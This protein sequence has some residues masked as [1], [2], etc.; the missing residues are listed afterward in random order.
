M[1]SVTINADD[2]PI[3]S[4]STAQMPRMTRQSTAAI[5][6]AVGEDLALRL[7]VGL[8]CGVTGLALLLFVIALVPTVYAGYVYFEASG[9]D[10]QCDLDILGWLKVI[11]WCTVVANACMAIELQLKDGP[12]GCVK[13]VAGF[14]AGIYWWIGVLTGWSN[15]GSKCDKVLF[16]GWRTFVVLGPTSVALVIV[17]TLVSTC[18][19][20]VYTKGQIQSAAAEVE[21]RRTMREPFI[22]EGEA[23]EGQYDQPPSTSTY[24][25]PAPNPVTDAMRADRPNVTVSPHYRQ[26]K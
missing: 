26:L 23:L 2:E 22:V 21:R 4:I 13:A 16:D 25:P 15:D 6:Q 5:K 20:A 10:A 17:L 14:V 8:G 9:R 24:R 19:A 12:F 1:K 3:E 18:F 7:A 11:L